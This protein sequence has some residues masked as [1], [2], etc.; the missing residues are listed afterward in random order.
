MV[1]APDEPFAFEPLEHPL[2]HLHAAATVARGDGRQVA[3]PVADEVR[4]R[5]HRRVDHR[6]FQKRRIRRLVRVVA[7]GVRQVLVKDLSED[8]G[9]GKTAD[10]QHVDVQALV[11]REV[12][13]TE[14]RP[15]PEAPIHH[16]PAVR[17]QHPLEVREA[18]R[19]GV[20]HR[21]RQRLERCVCRELLLD[22]REHR[23]GGGGNDVV[24]RHRG[25][26]PRQQLQQPFEKPPGRFAADPED[27]VDVDFVE[28]EAIR[29]F[30]GASQLV[31]AGARAVHRLERP[32]AP[33]LH[34]AAQA[35][36]TVRT[37]Q[38]QRV[39]TQ[40]ARQELERAPARGRE[41]EVPVDRSE[42]AVELRLGEQVRGAAADV[43]KLDEP[44]LADVGEELDFPLEPLE[45]RGNLLVR[46]A[47]RGAALAE[48]AD[49]R[50][51]RDVRVQPV[52]MAGL[53]IFEMPRPDLAH[54]A[55]REPHGLRRE[56]ADGGQTDLFG[57]AAVVTERL[58]LEVCHAGAGMIPRV[59][60]KST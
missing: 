36:E 49:L 22:A 50:A 15:L 60:H 13:V 48:A 58:G 46:L 6:G 2:D 53:P 33:R 7:F 55:A 23:I 8:V 41:P 12:P 30:D 20:G 47:Q 9:M 10:A 52:R 56:G 24:D 34:A 40:R 31:Q 4:D 51:E 57:R 21:L 25:R 28:P 18:P 45:V 14:L 39:G 32:I 54:L 11:V 27:E 42:Q 3:A 26:I 19:D 5:V 38:R 29:L 43:L 1:T 44:R 35:V 37:H 17:P 59:D 16:H